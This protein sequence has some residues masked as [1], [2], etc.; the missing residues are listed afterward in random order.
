MI[1]NQDFNSDVKEWR[2]LLPGT[3]EPRLTLLGAR[4]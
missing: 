1:Q 3:S 2:F 4:A